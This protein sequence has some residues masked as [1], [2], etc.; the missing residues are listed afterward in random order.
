MKEII[1]IQFKDIFLFEIIEK[2][3]EEK[4]KRFYERYKMNIFF[5]RREKNKNLEKMVGKIYNRSKKQKRQYGLDRN[6][7]KRLEE[8]LAIRKEDEYLDMVY[9]INKKFIEIASSSED[10]K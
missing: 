1:T 3:K 10:S 2:D 8:E 7:I 5:P 9:N 6:T 4:N